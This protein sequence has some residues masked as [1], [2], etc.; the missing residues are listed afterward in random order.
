LHRPHQSRGLERIILFVIARGR[1]REA[2]AGARFSVL[3]PL[4]PAFQDLEL[5]APAH[6]SIL[7][8]R[9]LRQLL[10]ADKPLGNGSVE[11]IPKRTW[12]RMEWRL[13]K[14]CGREPIRVPRRLRPFNG[15]EA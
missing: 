13:F 12:P 2:P 15:R 9:I 6:E 14:Q 8:L 10:V 1:E 3:E 11:P 7:P 5:A 4:R